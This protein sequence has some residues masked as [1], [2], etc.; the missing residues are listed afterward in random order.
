[1]YTV[2]DMLQHCSST[3]ASPTVADGSA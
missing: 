2:Q 3:T 1:M